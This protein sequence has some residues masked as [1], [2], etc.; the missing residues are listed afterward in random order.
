MA[1]WKSCIMTEVLCH[2]VGLCQGQG[3]ASCSLALLTRIWLGEKVMV[4]VCDSSYPVMDNLSFQY[5]S[6]WSKHCMRPISCFI[7][8]VVENKAGLL[9]HLLCTSYHLDD[10]K[11]TPFL[12]TEDKAHF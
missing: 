1:V 4:F 9:P 12:T 2:Q 8:L 3:C 6:H 5:E 7:L 10:I 11:I